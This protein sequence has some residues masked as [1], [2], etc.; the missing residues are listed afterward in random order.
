MT[1]LQE[2]KAKRNLL[3]KKENMRTMLVKTKLQVE[4][5]MEN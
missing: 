1:K 5:H 3:I 2:V 4:M